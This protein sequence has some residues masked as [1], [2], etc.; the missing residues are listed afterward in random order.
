MKGA[1][2][3]MRATTEV[4]GAPPPQALGESNDCAVR[5]LAV[6]ACLPYASAHA[7]FAA[8]GREP[9][10]TVSEA[11]VH[12][13]IA[14]AVPGAAFRRPMRGAVTLARFVA[15][16]PTGHYVVCTSNHALAVVDGVVHDWR[17]ARPRRRV[18]CYWR[19]V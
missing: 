18:V 8:A 7:L 14:A 4:Y 15:A 6:A 2:R 17:P 19:L 5:A 9:R 12:R 13:A 11:Q 1:A 10:Q 16:F 3:A